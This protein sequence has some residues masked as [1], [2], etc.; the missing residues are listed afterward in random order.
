MNQYGWSC[1]VAY[2]EVPRNSY[3]GSN[4]ESWVLQ[5]HPTKFHYKVAILNLFVRQSF[6]VS[7]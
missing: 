6:A 4:P 3:L 7:G 5:F 2:Q 1:G